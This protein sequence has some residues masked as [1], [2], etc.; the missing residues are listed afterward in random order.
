M[1]GHRTIVYAYK[2]TDAAGCEDQRHAF[3]PDDEEEADLEADVE[4]PLLVKAEH[5]KT[6]SAAVHKQETTPLEPAAENAAPA[7]DAQHDEDDSKGNVSV[8]VDTD[9]EARAAGP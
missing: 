4:D 9:V 1:P 8:G 2:P 6:S 5:K 7:T 3:E